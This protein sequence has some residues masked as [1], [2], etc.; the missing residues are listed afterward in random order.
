MNE[1][2]S[3]KHVSSTFRGVYKRKFDTK[4]R[5]E[6]TAGATIFADYSLLLS[7]VNDAYRA[8]TMVAAFCCMH[9]STGQMQ[10]DVIGPMSKPVV[11]HATHMLLSLQRHTTNMSVCS[12]IQDAE[13]AAWEVLPAKGRQQ[14][15]MTRQHSPSGSTSPPLLH[16]R[17]LYLS[18]ETL[19]S[20][21]KFFKRYKVV[22]KIALYLVASQGTKR[23]LLCHS[24]ALPF[25]ICLT[26]MSIYSDSNLFVRP[27]FANFPCHILLLCHL[28]SQCASKHHV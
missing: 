3:S 10:I 28:C 11:C 7:K 17:M 18:K 9:L 16:F 23:R 1:D 22:Q 6:I 25:L 12:I 8:K 14:K 21:I 27:N 26:H 2:D 19:F 4:W 20:N 24:Q 5:A 13:S 15:P